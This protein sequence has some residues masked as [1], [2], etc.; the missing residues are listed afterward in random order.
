VFSLVSLSLKIKEKQ[1]TKS[2]VPG[3]GHVTSYLNSSYVISLA[4]CLTGL[5]KLVSMTRI[6]DAMTESR[7]ES[8]RIQEMRGEERNRANH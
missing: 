5:R 7:K 6:S 1:R 3:L 4:V 8:I 2:Q